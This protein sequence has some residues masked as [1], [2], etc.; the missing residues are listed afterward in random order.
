MRVVIAVGLIFGVFS[1]SFGQSIAQNNIWQLLLKVGWTQ[2]M[3]PQLGV[4]IDYPV[5]SSAVKALNGK[6][7]QITGYVLPMIYGQNYVAL[8]A[9]PNASCFFCGG[10]GIESIVEVYPIRTRKYK[11][12]E[13]VTFKGILKLNETDVEHLIYILEKAQELF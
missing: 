6:E 8:S 7:I 3:S 12:D 5:F 13:I 4:E 9:Y 11:P 10:A 1:L 2:K